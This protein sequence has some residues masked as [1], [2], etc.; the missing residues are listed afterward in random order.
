[1]LARVPGVT[2]LQQLVRAKQRW[3]VSVAALAYR[4]NKLGR[5]S[6]WQYRGL[7]IEMQQKGY[8]KV[9]PE[10]IEPEQ[11]VLWQKIFAQLWSERTTRDRIAS[12]LGLPIAEL[13]NLV[14][15]LT[16][17]AA[18]IADDQQVSRGP[19]LVSSIL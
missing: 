6:D 18:P 16:G 2:S 12:E 4:L 7:C 1:M 10:P 13:D 8:T 9:E 15:G 5:V 3:K 11:S 19:R 14:F 17:G